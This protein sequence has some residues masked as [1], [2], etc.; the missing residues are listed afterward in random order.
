M[1]A[2]FIRQV[3]WRVHEW[4][5]EGMA[6]TARLF[7]SIFHQGVRYIVADDSPMQLRRYVDEGA[8]IIRDELSR[9][10]MSLQGEQQLTQMACGSPVPSLTVSFALARVGAP[11]RRWV[12]RLSLTA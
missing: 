12:K 5:G 4:V 6:A 7:Q 11:G 9:L 1:G 10:A 3:L 8:S 2:M